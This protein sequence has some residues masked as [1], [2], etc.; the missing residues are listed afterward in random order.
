MDQNS[1]PRVRP[2][3]E[4]SARPCK[5]NAITNDS[6]RAVLNN[7]EWFQNTCIAIIAG[8]REKA[9]AAVIQAPSLSIA[10][11]AIP[12]RRPT[13]YSLCER[14]GPPRTTPRQSPYCHRHTRLKIPP[15][16][17]EEICKS[18]P[19]DPLASSS[20]FPPTSAVWSLVLATQDNTLPL[21]GDLQY[22][23]QEPPLSVCIYL[24]IQNIYINV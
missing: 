21:L 18:Q 13:L 9:S 24:L 11:T 4:R 2:P 6:D 15:W 16:R 23:P 19:S 7:S 10:D 1:C 22:V 20:M 14:G 12:Q 3:D 5:L 8:E 17:E